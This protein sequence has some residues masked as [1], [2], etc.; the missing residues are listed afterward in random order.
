M[1]SC[2]L[3]IFSVVELLKQCFSFQAS[4]IARALYDEP[5]SSTETEE[6]YLLS[7]SKQ[8]EDVQLEK[9]LT[10][11]WYELISTAYT[12]IT[13]LKSLII[14]SVKQIAQ[15]NTMD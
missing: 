14:M 4:V 11:I 12:T 15:L 5:V 6:L 2:C 8:S 3:K 7:L 9:L 13:K 1:M 10:K